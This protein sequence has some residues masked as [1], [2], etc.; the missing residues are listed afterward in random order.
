MTERKA[1]FVGK[2]KGGTHLDDGRR[3]GRMEEKSEKK[4]S[5]E[6]ALSSLSLNEDTQSQEDTDQHNGSHGKV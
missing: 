4:R 6:E 5:D 3:T 2:Q 1:V